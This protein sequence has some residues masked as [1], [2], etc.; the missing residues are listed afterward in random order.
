M[1]EHINYLKSLH[2]QLVE[3]SVQIDDKEPAMTLLA[4]LPDEFMPSFTALDAVGETNLSF[5][6]VKA[7][8]LNHFDRKSD[9]F[10]FKKS[11]DALS[12][13]HTFK[14]GGEEE[15][16]DAFPLCILIN[17]RDL[18][19]RNLSLE[20]VTHYCKARGHFARDCPKKKSPNVHGI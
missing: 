7:M 6:K 5:E 20:F 3:M 9:N 1:L 10:E 17:Q 13:K 16:A 11:G 18:L 2:D 14:A 8:L 4:D 15:I 12:V 19:Q